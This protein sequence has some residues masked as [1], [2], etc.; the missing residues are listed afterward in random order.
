MTA[1][2]Q[3]PYDRVLRNCAQPGVPGTA[4]APDSMRKDVLQERHEHAASGDRQLRERSCLFHRAR[5]AA[6]ARGGAPASGMA[7]E[8]T[9]LVPV[10]DRF[11]KVAV[12]SSVKHKLNILDQ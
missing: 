12:S 2:R 3:L 11:L 4:R 6:T 5:T 9:R 1:L 7:F 8:P 10:P